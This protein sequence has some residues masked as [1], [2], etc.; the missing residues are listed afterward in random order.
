LKLFSIDFTQ[1]DRPGYGENIYRI[2]TTA[3]QPDRIFSLSKTS[4]SP[5]T[6]NN[7]FLKRSKYFTL[8]SK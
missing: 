4:D 8:D 7:N 6:Q 1:P 5:Q 2:K 3:E